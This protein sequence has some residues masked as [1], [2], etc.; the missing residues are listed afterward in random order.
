M[1]S[2]TQKVRKRLYTIIYQA[3]TL[4]GKLF[5]LVLIFLILVSTAAVMLESIESVRYRY[6]YELNML[7][8]IITLFFTL[9]YIGRLFAVEK[10]MKFIVS[11]NG[12]VDLLATVPAY[13]GLLFPGV[14]FL[15]SIR[16]IRLLRIFRILKMYHFVGAS[17][18]LVN[19]LSRSR[20]KIVVFLFSVV[21]LCIILGTIMYLIEGAE[22]G[23]TSIPVAVYWTIVT[24]TTVGFGDITP[25]TPAGQFVSMVIMIL[26]YGIIAVPTGLV[27]AEYMAR[28]KA[29]AKVCPKCKTPN[30]EEAVYCDKC[31]QGF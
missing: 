19:A 5:D 1:D 12:I 24:L 25:L 11:R 9:E 13:I 30:R 4:P 28:D 22:S 23:F 6:G 15:I 26:G 20:Q 14:H 8:W 17:D 18:Q 29:P 21:V 16:S 7:E 27:T 10:P 31:G 2:N 3:D